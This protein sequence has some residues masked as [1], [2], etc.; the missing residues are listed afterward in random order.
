MMLLLSEA[1]AARRRWYFAC[2]DDTDGKTPETGLTFAAGELQ[3]SKNGAAFGNVAG[4]ATEVSDGLYYYEATAGEL[5]T[6]G[7][8][9]FKVE[10]SG[11]RLVLM[12]VGQVV[13]TD[14]YTAGAT[15][16]QVDTLEASA[17]AIEADTQDIQSRLPAALVSGRIDAS[18][19]A[20]AANV[21]T[22]AAAAA[23][24]TTE[25]Q[26]GLATA[27]A[28][29][30][31]P[32]NAELATALDPL[33]TAAEVTAAT[34]PLATAA[35]LATVAGYLD[36][37]VAAILAAVDTEVGALVTAVAD[38]P[39]NAELATALDP[40]AT[41]AEIAALD[42]VVDRI[43]ADTQDIQSRI[44]AALVGGRMD[45]SVGAMAANVLTAAATAAD[46]GT[47]VRTGLATSA[48]IAALDTALDAVPAGV[49]AAI[50]EGAETYGDAI[51]LLTARILG[52][53]TVP[54]GD[55]SYAFRDAAD[56]KD[57]IAGTMSGT[58]RTVTTRDGT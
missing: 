25:L 23:D 55:G 28:V 57:R 19:G 58:A 24:L 6:V 54:A 40:L 5:D 9:A 38:L 49:W 56:S 7:A 1:T 29:A 3:L 18:V 52:N 48:E 50:A 47:E 2:V 30:D 11:V 10:K 12:A 4:T 53:A 33:A 15:S 27:A 45:S 39:T 21:M 51:R 13:A 44:P 34:S 35:N 41:S 26:S 43:E 20:M 17:T 36:T 31:L 14:P 42:T 46:F 16:A 22:A 32:T 8:L 37:E